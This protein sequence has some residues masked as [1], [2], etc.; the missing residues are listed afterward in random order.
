MLEF[1]PP[2]SGFTT[3]VGEG[4]GVG[5]NKASISERVRGRVKR[6]IL[7]AVVKRG[8]A[9]RVLS[10]IAEKA[11]IPHLTYWIEP[12]ESF[13]QLQKSGTVKTSQALPERGAAS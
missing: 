7:T 3:W 9:E 12:V 2:I 13:G 11:P 1:D 8:L 10:E 5:F 6:T 4:H